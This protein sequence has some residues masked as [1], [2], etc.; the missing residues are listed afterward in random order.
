MSTWPF[1]TAT[2]ID[3]A[4]SI[5]EFSADPIV[6]VKFGDNVLNLTYTNVSKSSDNLLFTLD[7]TTISTAI[8]ANFSSLFGSSA[9]KNGI[10]NCNYRITWT[11]LYGKTY[12]SPNAPIN[13]SFEENPT[14]T[15]VESQYATS[16]TGSWVD[17]SSSSYLQET[18]YVRPQVTL[19]WYTDETITGR[20]MYSIDGGTTYNIWS[21]INYAAAGSSSRTRTSATII[22]DAKALPEITD[23]ADWKFKAVIA[24]NGQEIESSPKTYHATKHTAANI[25]INSLSYNQDNHIVTANLN[26]SSLGYNSTFPTGSDGTGTAPKIVSTSTYLDDKNHT[27]L[28]T[29]SSN[30]TEGI[31]N[32]TIN[33]NLG[34]I[35]SKQVCIEYTST[36]KGFVSTTKTTYSLISILYNIMPT[37]SYR[38]NKIGI[39]TNNLSNDSVIE[40]ASATGKTKL[41]VHF[42]DGTTGIINLSN[43]TIDNFIIDGGTW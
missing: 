18:L 3:N 34:S 23:T 32:Y 7:K 9:K 40:I 12:I 14:L 21:T 26:V 6:Q 16:S 22:G 31:N 39:N 27:H 25:I 35:E 8:L 13:I 36:I 20:F 2:S 41:I 11:N 38:K 33:Y 37:V 29:I 28:S 17:L 19:N 10:K 30:L 4:E 24:K 1:G 43:K 15:A 5:Y 42:T